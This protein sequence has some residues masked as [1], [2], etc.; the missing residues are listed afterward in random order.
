MSVAEL[1]AEFKDLTEGID[2][3]PALTIVSFEC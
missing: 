2:L 1:R 3:R